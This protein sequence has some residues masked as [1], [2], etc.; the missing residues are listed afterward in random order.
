MALDLK[1]CTPNSPQCSVER[2]A[3]SDWMWDE[4]LDPAAKVVSIYVRFM[5]ED[6]AVNFS[7][8]WHGNG[9]GRCMV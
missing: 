4:V 8:F 2:D 1:K 9:N 5:A 6:G 7:V 3:S